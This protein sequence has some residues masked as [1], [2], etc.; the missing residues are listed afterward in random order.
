MVSL[1]LLRCA[2]DK[3]DILGLRAMMLKCTTEFELWN[4]DTEFE[5]RRLRW[6]CVATRGSTNTAPVLW[7]IGTGF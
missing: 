3:G 1:I 4:A 6:R 5:G 7:F 2:K